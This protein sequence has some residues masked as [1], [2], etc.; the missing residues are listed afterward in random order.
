MSGADAVRRLTEKF[1]SALTVEEPVGRDHQAA[2]VVPKERLRDVL[3]FMKTD[4]ALLYTMMTDL[5]AVDHYG[6]APRFEIVYLMSSVTL[7]DRLAV[8]VRAGDGEPVPTV[9]DMWRAAEW[10][11]REAYDMFGLPF[12]NHP[13]L[14][15]I[16]M[17]EDF[18]GYPLRKDFPIEGYGFDEPFRVNLDRA[19]A[20][21]GGEPG[22]GPDRAGR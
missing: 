12:E 11:E 5:F 2:V 14:R 1:G 3:L 7:K 20:G 22:A 4:E 16:L 9:S 21:E 10:L 13:D 6:D 15:R 17:V 18:E 19:Q 8:K